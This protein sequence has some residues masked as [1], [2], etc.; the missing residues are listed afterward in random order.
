MMG[1]YLDLLNAANCE[2]GELIGISSHNS[3]FAASQEPYGGVFRTLEARCPAL[4]EPPR[5]QQAVEDGRRFLAQWGEQAEALGWSSRDLFG[6]HKPPDKPHPSYS[7]LS[8]YDAAG[9]LWLLQ[10]RSITA[11]SSNTAAIVGPTGSVTKYRKDNKPALG[12]LGDSL[13]DLGWP[14]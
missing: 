3:Q 5:W 10:G 9:L 14:T 8:R 12:P 11:M 1:R 13:D 6:L 2:K 7:R 4:V